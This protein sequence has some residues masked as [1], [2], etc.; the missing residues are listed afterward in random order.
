MERT[1]RPVRRVLRGRSGRRVRTARSPGL[2]AQPALPDLQARLVQMGQ[3]V[4]TAQRD[5]QDR[6]DLL[7]PLE[8]TA[9]TVLMALQAQLVLQGL[10][11]PQGRPGPVG[12]GEP[13]LGP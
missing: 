10:L 11:V 4:L 1:V 7:A 3:T 9:R 6:P 13:S 12:P 8:R 5:L 2:L